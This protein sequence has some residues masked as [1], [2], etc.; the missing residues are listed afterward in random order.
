MNFEAFPK[1][2]RLSRPIIITEKIDGSNG[3]LYIQSHEEFNVE[4]GYD[5]EKDANT[6]VNNDWVMRVGSRKRWLDAS[7]AGDHFGFFK[8]AVVNF[9]ELCLGLGPGRHYGEWW[10]QGIQ[11]GY[12]L[13]EKR[14]SLFNTYRW[15]KDT[16]PECCHTVPVLDECAVFNSQVIEITLNMLKLSGSRAA[17][18]FA[19]PEGIVVYHPHGNILMKKTFE[20]DKVFDPNKERADG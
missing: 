5:A 8:W 6:I 4:N 14:F 10:G 17:P 11:R 20:G 1:I 16:K 12:G 19:K 3:Q 18:G 15:N 13:D 2:P 9:A 7:K